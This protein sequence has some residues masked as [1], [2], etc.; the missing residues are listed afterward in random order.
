LLIGPFFAACGSVQ[1]GTATWGTTAWD[2]HLSLAMAG[3]S[4]LMRTDRDTHF[5]FACRILGWRSLGW[6]H[7]PIIKGTSARPSSSV[8]VLHRVSVPADSKGQI[9]W[10]SPVQWVSPF[11]ESAASVPSGS[12]RDTHPVTKKRRRGKPAQVPGECP[13]QDSGCPHRQTT[14]RRSEWLSQ[15][16]APDHVA[17]RVSS[18]GGVFLLT[19]KARYGESLF[20]GT[21]AVPPPGWRHPLASTWQPACAFLTNR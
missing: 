7:P 5:R 21:E 16:R 4:H 12:R 2:S 15:V 1:M 17:L 13:R 11:S 20:S 14:R 18:F 3:D 8:G 6:G 10:V 19:R 9:R